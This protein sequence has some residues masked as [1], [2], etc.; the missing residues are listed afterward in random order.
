MSSDVEDDFDDS[1]F[2]FTAEELN[3]IDS[4]ISATLSSEAATSSNAV[5]TSGA[6]SHAAVPHAASTSAASPHIRD[7]TE[8]ENCDSPDSSFA[9]DMFQ[10]PQF[11]NAL[12]QSLAQMEREHVASTRDADPLT[13]SPPPTL[14]RANGSALFLSFDV[15]CRTETQ[16]HISGSVAGDNQHAQGRS[17]RVAIEVG[18]G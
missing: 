7:V 15:A 5:H 3:E 18:S 6:L 13:D 16:G 2:N 10:D 1:D 8:I 14:L 9:D 11:L 17:A 12:D 4:A